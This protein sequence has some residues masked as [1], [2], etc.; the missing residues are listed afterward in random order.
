MKPA[1][2]MPASRAS[3]SRTAQNSAS[4]AMLVRCPAMVKERLRRPCDMRRSTGARFG[5]DHLFRAHETIEFLR[6]DI[7]EAHRFFFQRRAVL[8]R[9]LGY[10]GR[11]VIADRGRK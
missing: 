9:H 10:L 3:A 6:G 4:R 1:T 5:M 11:I 2:L 7:A 8:V